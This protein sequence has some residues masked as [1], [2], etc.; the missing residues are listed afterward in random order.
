MLIANP[1]VDGFRSYLY[2]NVWK[3]IRV[4]IRRIVGGGVGCEE[5]TKNGVILR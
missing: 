1:K 3:N 4:I 5:P 2:Q